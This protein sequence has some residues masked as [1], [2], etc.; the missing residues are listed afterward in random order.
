MFEINQFSTYYSVS[1]GPIMS[2]SHLYISLSSIKPAEKP[3]TG[4]LFNSAKQYNF[5][6]F[7]RV[8]HTHKSKVVRMSAIATDTVVKIDIFVLVRNFA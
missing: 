6:H 5:R 2:T 3:S 1:G 7:H 8:I 4:F